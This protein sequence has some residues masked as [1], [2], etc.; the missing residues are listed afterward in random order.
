MKIRRATDLTEQYNGMDCQ[1]DRY[2]QKKKNAQQIYWK[3]SGM[4]V[5]I[6]FAEAL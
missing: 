6:N 4:Q 2:N 1:S 3:R 5:A